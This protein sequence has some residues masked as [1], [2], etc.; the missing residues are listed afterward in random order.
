MPNPLRRLY[1][2]TVVLARHKH[3]ES[4][5]FGVSFAE[6]SFFPI[7]PDALLIP[8]AMAHPEKAW[9]FAAVCT[10][11][12]VLGGI[13]GYAIG[14]LL[15]H[16]V[17]L[18]VLAFYHLAEK[19]SHFEA[20]YREWGAWIILLKGLT[21]IPFKLVTIVSGAAHYPLWAFIPLCAITRGVR[22]F[23][24]AGL[25]KWKGDAVRHH[26]EK[27]LEI[28]SLLFLALILGGVGLFVWLA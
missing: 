18:P 15:W 24:I 12:S 6:S 25:I 19:A 11:G 8:M 27:N 14:A 10:L 21:P 2:R 5:L 7:P 22:F 16:A 28:L 13:A 3:A 20:L 1:A 9:R 23:G 4:A 17:G 26:L